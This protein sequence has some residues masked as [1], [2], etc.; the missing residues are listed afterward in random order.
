M[1]RS[2][3]LV[4]EGLEAL[5]LGE[6]EVGDADVVVLAEEDVLALEVAVVNVVALG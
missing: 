2:D 6:S 5:F 1:R 4:F 3:R